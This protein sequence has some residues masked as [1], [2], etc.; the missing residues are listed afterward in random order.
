MSELNALKI[1]DDLG[2]TSLRFRP[3]TDEPVQMLRSLTVCAQGMTREE[4]VLLR[5]KVDIKLGFKLMYLSILAAEKCVNTGQIDWLRAAVCAHVVEGMK[6]DYRENLLRLGAVEYAAW[7][8]GASVPSLLD[9]FKPI[10]S[11]S[12]FEQLR[13]ALGN[14]RGKNALWAVGMKEEVRDGASVF[15]SEK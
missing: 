9:P 3:K 6:G 5:Q 7:K 15:I 13:R 11:S 8:I 12:E 14:G 1:L 2:A 4:L 10:L